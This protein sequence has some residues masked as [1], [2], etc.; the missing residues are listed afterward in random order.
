MSWIFWGE[1]FVRSALLMAAIEGVRQVSKSL[2]ARYRHFIVLVGFGL[3][4]VL[5]VLTFILPPIH[6]PAFFASGTHASVTVTTTMGTASEVSRE[7]GNSSLLDWPLLIWLGGA[8]VML[9]S[10]F[11]GRLLLSRAMQRARLL[12]DPHW[13]KL[14]RELADEL[15][16]RRTPRLLMMPDAVMPFA[17]GLFRPTILLPAGCLHWT[18]MRK[19]IV[20]VHELT[21]I[22]RRDGISQLFANVVAALWWFQPLAWL[23]RKRLR[24]E[25]EHACDA[26]VLAIGVRASDYATQLVDIARTSRLTLLSRAAICMARKDELEPRLVRILAPQR[27]GSFLRAFVSATLV[28]AI[29]ATAPAITLRRNHS[30]IGGS[31]MKRT[32]LTGLLATATLSA[33]TISGSL[34]DTTGVAIPDAKLVL[35]SADTSADLDTT[36]GPD[37]KF[38]FGDLSAGQYILR[39]EKPGFNDLLREF[40]VKQDSNIERGLVMQVKGVE[41][42]PQADSSSHMAQPFAPDRIRV[43]G[44]VAE[45]NLIR[46]VQPVYPAA[47]KA[48]HVQGTVLLQMIILKDG[49]PGEITVTSSPSNDLSQA[50]ID[51]VRQ[52]RYR[53]ILLNGQPVQVVTQVIVNYTLSQ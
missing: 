40:T 2:P 8:I 43:K 52:W 35:H 19:R 26:Q 49:T 48:A 16:M 3:L 28:I 42:K 51:A 46:K 53:P 15:A 33:A 44:D 39:V 14:L 9:S 37:G 30:N 34:F 20:L 12:S 27:A 24:Q 47:A 36:S 22:R 13:Q 38:S 23:A 32:L 25:S 50:S 17:F 11:V 4:A 41:E 18:E 5:P 1:L 10:P 31:H 6:I 29:A 45:A 7:T 21:H